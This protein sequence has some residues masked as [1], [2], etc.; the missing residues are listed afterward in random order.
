M[1]PIFPLLL[2]LII[3]SS[4]TCTDET[5]KSSKSSTPVSNTTKMDIQNTLWHLESMTLAGKKEAIFP[6]TL[7]IGDQKISGKGGCNNF[8]GKFNLENDRI[9]ISRI[10]STRMYCQDKSKFETKYLRALEKVTSYTHEKGRLSLMLPDGKL[11]FSD[12]PMKKS[13]PKDATTS[14]EN[15]TWHLKSISDK[16]TT[17]TIKDKITLLIAKNKVSGNGGCN[18][19][20]GSLR[21]EGNRFGVSK[22]I[23]TEMYCDKTSPT[24][25]KFLQALEAVSNYTIKDNQL[26]LTYPDGKL[27][28]GR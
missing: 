26:I 22:I 5:S 23:A 27:F 9:T 18:D 11:I 14:I 6:A 15:V 12:K 24:E 16:R 25:M 19:Y 7:K 8:F 2:M 20:S 4:S 13:T 28:F 17:H 21:M 3:F 10:G 1:K